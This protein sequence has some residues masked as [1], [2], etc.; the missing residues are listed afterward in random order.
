LLEKKTEKDVDIRQK[1]IDN[2]SS[3]DSS[4]CNEEEENS[5]NEN[6]KEKK[7][8]ETKKKK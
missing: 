4:Q 5:V 6:G 8:K 2:L 3:S 7:M 1:C